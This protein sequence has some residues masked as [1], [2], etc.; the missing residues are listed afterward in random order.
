VSTLRLKPCTDLT[1]P[2][3]QPRVRGRP[4]AAV[5]FRDFPPPGAAAAR[6]VH[7][8]PQQPEEPRREPFSSGPPSGVFA[9][10]AAV[11][12][13]AA[14]RPARNRQAPSRLDL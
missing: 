11:L 14:A 3:V 2:P 12:N 4:P 6:H 5:R 1:A 9:C 10:P 13:H 7:F 8:A